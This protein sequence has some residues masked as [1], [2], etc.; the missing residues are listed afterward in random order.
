MALISLRLTVVFFTACLIFREATPLPVS[1]PTIPPSAFQSEALAPLALWMLTCPE[2]TLATSVRVIGNRWSVD[3][4]DFSFSW[5]INLWSAMAFAWMMVL[6]GGDA[7]SSQV[8]AD[9]AL[10]MTHIPEGFTL[11][12]KNTTD[13]SLGE[14]MPLEIWLSIVDDLKSLLTATSM[15]EEV[16]VDL[17]ETNPGVITVRVGP[18]WRTP[19]PATTTAI[20]K[21][22]ANVNPKP[23]F[24]WTSGEEG[25]EWATF[26]FRSKPAVMPSPLPFSTPPPLP[27]QPSPSTAASGSNSKMSFR[28]L[29]KAEL[30]GLSR[31]ALIF[32]L[33]DGGSAIVDL[34][35]RQIRFIDSNNGEIGTHPFSKHS[36]SYTAAAMSPDG[37]TLALAHPEGL[38]IEVVLPQGKEPVKIPFHFG[39]E[40]PL[41]RLTADGK[42]V[43]AAPSDGPTFN[44][45]TS[46]CAWDSATGEIQATLS[47]LPKRGLIVL[48]NGARL[49][50]YATT[51]KASEWVLA[52]NE[53]KLTHSVVP[54]KSHTA[55]L[56]MALSED[57]STLALYNANNSLSIYRLDQKN[58]QI[59]WVLSRSIDVLTKA[60]TR[61]SYQLYLSE[62]GNV[63]ILSSAKGNFQLYRL[64]LDSITSFQKRL[65]PRQI[66]RNSYFRNG[67]VTGLNPDG[68]V[69][70]GTQGQTAQ[71]PPFD[72]LGLLSADQ[73]AL[74]ASAI[75]KWVEDD[76]NMKRLS[77]P[78]ITPVVIRKYLSGTASMPIRFLFPILSHISRH[79]PETLITAEFLNTAVEN[80]RIRLRDELKTQKPAE[81]R[82]QLS[83]GWE[84][85]L[86]FVDGSRPTIPL[87]DLAN[88]L[89]WAFQTKPAL[90]IRASA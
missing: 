43:I 77:I 1:R 44:S 3:P 64:S 76:S 33:Q 14:L 38:R 29:S 54:T 23:T 42:R 83:I 2:P 13:K 89:A 55:I 82:P 47:G 28:L 80:A 36:I 58:D 19:R 65:S 20:Q 24:E 48:R 7:I 34:A 6:P 61:H 8:Q 71:L 63:V 41:L 79:Y 18:V 66:L 25:E 75:R 45:K 74:L 85:F 22:F 87:D 53:Y 88:T 56:A 50:T 30:P 69:R 72:Y 4:S 35:A 52:G 16:F 27:P 15:N 31:T 73:H 12:V 17:K 59:R 39:Q 51:G 26:I 40:P 67:V 78:K 60:V 32:S 5:V 46:V 70:Y 57:E 37:K 62:D 9:R 86:K 90:H 49:L 81:T 68:L 11:S 84:E 10:L 21:R